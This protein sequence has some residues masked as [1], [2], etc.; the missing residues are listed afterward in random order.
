MMRLTC[1]DVS[2]SMPGPLRQRVEALILQRG[3]DN[4]VTQCDYEVLAPTVDEVLELAT[5]HVKEMHALRSW[6]QEYWVH[7]RARIQPI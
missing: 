5:V 3:A 4:V 1:Q 7:M 6:P 2:E